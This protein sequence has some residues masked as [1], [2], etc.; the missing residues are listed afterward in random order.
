MK[1]MAAEYLER[2]HQFE[3]MAS[4]ETDPDVKAEFEKQ[5]LAYQKLAA[6]RAEEMGLPLPKDQ[7]NSKA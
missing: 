6:K 5:A 2:A 1:K 7:P 4:H 3:R